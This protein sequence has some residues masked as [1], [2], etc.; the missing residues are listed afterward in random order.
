[1]NQW[2]VEE[3]EIVTIWKKRETCSLTC[4]LTCS[5]VDW[6]CL[7]STILL[8]LFEFLS[9]TNCKLFKALRF[10]I[11]NIMKKFW[12][13][14]RRDIYWFDSIYLIVSSNTNNFFISWFCYCDVRLRYLLIV[15]NIQL[16][17]WILVI[18]H[19]IKHF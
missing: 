10:W 17:A 11:N 12:F 7:S 4:S 1:M 2:M 3:N 13:Q 6:C 9:L 15:W 18:F 14:K 5:I 19:N 8:K 16:I